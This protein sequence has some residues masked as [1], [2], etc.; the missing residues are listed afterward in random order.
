MNYM[1]GNARPEH[2]DKGRLL[3]VTR[4][5]KGHWINA[6]KRNYGGTAK[7][8]KGPWKEG[9]E[10]GAYGIDPGAGA[11][12]AVVNYNGDFA[13]GQFDGSQSD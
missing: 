2:I 8:M 4:D 3:L 7:F 1:P 11:V 6:V 10:L 13:V 12:W 9:Y 5:G